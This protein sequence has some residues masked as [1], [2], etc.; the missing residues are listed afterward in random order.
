VKT[1]HIGNAQTMFDDVFA[2]VPRHL[3][4]QRDAMGGQGVQR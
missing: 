1:G 2:K 3:R 4:E